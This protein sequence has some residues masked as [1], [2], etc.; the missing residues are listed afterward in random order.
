[1]T[2][3]A[4]GNWANP[5][6]QEPDEIRSC[7]PI[8]SARQT[9][10]SR[11]TETFAFP[12]SSR[13]SDDALMLIHFASCVVVRPERCLVSRT[14]SAMPQAIKAYRPGCCSCSTV[15]RRRGL[16]FAV[17][18][19]PSSTSKAAGELVAYLNIIH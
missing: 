19:A 2:F 8:R 4:L 7:T 1:M 13:E 5:Y 6:A 3:L 15:K 14:N 10:N 17:E 9:R 12:S 11:S 18:R 16:R